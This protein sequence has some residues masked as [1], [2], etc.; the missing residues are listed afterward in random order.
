MVGRW[1]LGFYFVCV[2]RDFLM[3]FDVF[4]ILFIFDACGFV[5]A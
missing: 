2:N 1:L 4:F 5:D 3:Y